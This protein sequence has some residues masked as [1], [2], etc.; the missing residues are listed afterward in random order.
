FTSHKNKLIVAWPGSGVKR[1]GMRWNACVFCL[2]CFHDPGQSAILEARGEAFHFHAP[3]VP[4]LLEKENI[5][6]SL[7]VTD[8]ALVSLDS[9]GNPL[10]SDRS[11]GCLS[12]HG[13]KIVA[14]SAQDNLAR[15]RTNRCVDVSVKDL[16]ACPLTR[17]SSHRGGNIGYP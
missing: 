13:T 6:M 5:A 2:V 8:T 12:S 3:V 14:N 4:C 16:Q 11:N 15:R 1:S 7:F 10:D 9:N 17:L